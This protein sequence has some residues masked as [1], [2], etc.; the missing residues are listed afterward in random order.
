MASRT[1]LVSFLLL[2]LV[3]QFLPLP[4]CCDSLQRHSPRMQVLSVRV[5]VAVLKYSHIY[6]LPFFPFMPPPSDSGWTFDYIN[7]HNVTSQTRSKRPYGFHPVCQNT[8]SWSPELWCEK[9][10]YSM[11]TT[12]ERPNVRPQV[13]SPSFVYFSPDSQGSRLKSEEAI[14]IGYL[15]LTRGV[16]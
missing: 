8:H 1:K 16:L 15:W 10:S 12:V 14:L 2:S 6:S 5:S 3:N 9:S 11:T 7:R 4:I 13:N